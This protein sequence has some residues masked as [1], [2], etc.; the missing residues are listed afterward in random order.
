MEAQDVMVGSEGGV[1]VGGG[2]VNTLAVSQ[3]LMIEHEPPHLLLLDPRV[4]TT[5]DIRSEVAGL[6]RTIEG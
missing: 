5:E 6:S 3:T 4:G 2:A 1:G